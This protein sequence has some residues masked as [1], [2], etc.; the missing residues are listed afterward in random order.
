MAE[1]PS[2]RPGRVPHPPSSGLLSKLSATR[3]SGKGNTPTG[4]SLRRGRLVAGGGVA[5]QSW[6]TAVVAGSRFGGGGDTIEAAVVTLQRVMRGHWGRGEARLWIEELYSLQMGEE[7]GAEW[8]ADQVGDE[9]Y[10]GHL[11]SDGDKTLGT[12]RVGDKGYDEETVA[13]GGQEEETAISWTA[14]DYAAYSDALKAEGASALAFSASR[15]LLWH[16]RMRTSCLRWR[17]TSS[18]VWRLKAPHC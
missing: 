2:A 6:E 10:E 16:C 4:G 17:D 9:G 18:G 7:E 13:E 8:G 3:G 11:V 5:C 1:P 12:S 15:I 14:E